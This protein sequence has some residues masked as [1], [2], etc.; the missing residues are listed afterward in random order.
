MRPT[1]HLS[2]II[3]VYN[4]AENIRPM[5]EAV[6]QALDGTDYELIYVDDGSRDETMARLKEVLDDRMRIVEFR[7]NY[8]QS[9]AL[10]AGIAAARGSYLCTMDGDL[11]NDPLDVPDM[12][13]LAETGGWDLV[14]GERANRQDGMFLRK[15][16]SL[17]ANAIIRSATGVHIRDYGCTL[18]VFRS[19][20][21]KDMGLYGELHRFIP[22]LASLEGARITQVPVR[23]HARIHGTSKYGIGRTFKVISDLLLMVF[24]RRYMLKPMHLFGTTGVIAM[25][26]GGMINLYLLWLKIQGQDIWGKPLLILGMLLFLGGIQII[27]T[28]IVLEMMMRTYYESQQKTVYRIRNIIDGTARN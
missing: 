25:V 17:I 19:E 3:C 13:R 26:I 1:P 28:G 14:A 12:L 16:P 23:H 15:I 2:I 11:Q 24:F 8:G 9:A 21:A 10:A 27:T 22:V 18:K 4:E 7:K 20:I 6:R 5:T